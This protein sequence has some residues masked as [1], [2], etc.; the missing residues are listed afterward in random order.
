M[1]WT[2]YL[3]EVQAAGYRWTELG[4][5]GYLPTDPGVLRDELAKRDLTL[6]GRH[7]LRRAAQGQRTRST[8]AKADC[9]AEMAHA[10]ARSAPATS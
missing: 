8:Q 10:S 9:D 2:R 3:D 5:F 4:P 7:G 6:T 1:P